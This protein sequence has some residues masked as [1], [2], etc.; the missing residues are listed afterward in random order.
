MRDLE[1]EVNSRKGRRGNGAQTGNIPVGFG[2]LGN[3]PSVPGLSQGRF[4]TA[5]Y[6][7]N[8]IALTQKW[9]PGMFS[10]RPQSEAWTVSKYVPLVP[11]EQPSLKVL[12]RITS[13]RQTEPTTFGGNRKLSVRA[14]GICRSCWHAI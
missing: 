5:K 2:K 11:D 9:S 13:S 6:F 8:G 12:V 10:M 14:D 1:N 3:V 7:L 4:T